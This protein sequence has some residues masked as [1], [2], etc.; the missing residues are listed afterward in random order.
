M[1]R[2][3]LQRPNCQR[4]GA[5]CKRLDRVFCSRTCAMTG[6]P[7]PANKGNTWALKATGETKWAH[8]KRMQKLCPKGPCIQCGADKTIIHHKDHNPFHT[9]SDNL[10]RL[11]RPCHARHHALERAA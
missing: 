6:V 9:V 8:Y 4:C 7:K 5:T 11:C 3:F 2:R 10:E 1:G